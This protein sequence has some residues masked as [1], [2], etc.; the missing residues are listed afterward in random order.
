MLWLSSC[1]KGWEIYPYLYPFAPEISWICFNNTHLCFQSSISLFVSFLL[2]DASVF[3]AD[4]F[5]PFLEPL[6]G[7]CFRSLP[8]LY[9]FS[10]HG[11]FTFPMCSY[12]IYLLSSSSFIRVFSFNSLR[13]QLPP[14]QVFQCITNGP[15]S[16]R[17]HQAV[18]FRPVKRITYCR[19]AFLSCRWKV[20]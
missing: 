8:L 19:P 16:A 18:L 3:L 12:L 7:P 1:G 15:D 11:I 20:D 10:T 17:Q 6:C 5:Y 9:M 2:L 4:P 14:C 13:Q